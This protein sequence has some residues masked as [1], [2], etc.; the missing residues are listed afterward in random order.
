[1]VGKHI[2]NCQPSDVPIPSN[3]VYLKGFSDSE[4]LMETSLK[5]PLAIEQF[6]PILETLVDLDRDDPKLAF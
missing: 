4:P 6:Q 2:Y 1:M 5:N 3:E